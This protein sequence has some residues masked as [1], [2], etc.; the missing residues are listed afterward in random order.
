MK[1]VRFATYAMLKSLLPLSAAILLTAAYVKML[2]GSL[3]AYQDVGRITA[4]DGG[5]LAELVSM[6]NPQLIF[7]AAF[8]GLLG[9]LFLGIAV[10]LGGPRPFPRWVRATLVV[11]LIP[12]ILFSIRGYGASFEPTDNNVA[13][14]I[15]Y[16]TVGLGCLAAILGLCW[17][18]RST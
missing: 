3:A 4:S 16:A 12:M 8:V 17:P 5:P 2:A 6:L 11:L 7:L 14:R 15:G 9:A 13:W 18:R 10:F 1:T